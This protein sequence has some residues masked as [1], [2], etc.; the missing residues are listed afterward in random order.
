MG[1]FE[2]EPAAFQTAK[3]RFNLPALCIVIQRGVRGLGGEEDEI[4]IPDPHPNDEDGHAPHTSWLRK[5]PSFSNPSVP[6]KPIRR[7]LIA[8]AGIRD[9]GIAFDTDA[10]PDPLPPEKFDPVSANKL[11]VSGETLNAVLA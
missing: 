5:D 2:V 3:E 7:H 8:A 6:K 10:K 4:V 11:A 1:V 9:A